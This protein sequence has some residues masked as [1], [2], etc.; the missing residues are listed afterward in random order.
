[1]PLIRIVFL[2]VGLAAIGTTTWMGYYGIGA[3]SAD[4][5]TS[6]RAGS[7]GRVIGTGGR[8]K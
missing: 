2:A 7:A 4:L 1:M 6:V 5:D 8:I 3:E